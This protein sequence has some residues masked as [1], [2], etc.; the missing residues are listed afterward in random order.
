VGLSFG[1]S[2]ERTQPEAGDIRLLAAMVNGKPTV[3]AMV[4]KGG[5]A[6]KTYEY[7]TPASG[8]KAFAFVGEVEGAEA[9]FDATPSGYVAQLRIPLEA[10]AGISF[11]AGGRLAFEAEVL[12]SGA[13]TRGLQTISRN[14]LYTSK[15]F[16]P[17]KMT[18]DIPAEA[19][20]YPAQWGTMLVK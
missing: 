12:C 17:A 16:S 14:H 6:Q 9:K 7:F 1:Q 19:W 4:P 10:L 3:V 11:E 15:G 5:K 13:G 18:D 20:L 2:G 8:K